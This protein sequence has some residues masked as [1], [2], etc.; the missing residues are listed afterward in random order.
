MISFFRFYVNIFYAFPF[1]PLRA[2]ANRPP[3]SF[4]LKWSPG[5]YFVCIT[6]QEVPHYEIVST[7]Y[8]S[9]NSSS[10]N[11]S[12]SLS[13]SGRSH[14]RGLKSA[15]LKGSQDPTTMVN[16]STHKPTL[17]MFV[18]VDKLKSNSLSKVFIKFV[19]S[20]VLRPI[21]KCYLTLDHWVSGDNS[22]R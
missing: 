20:A 7:P 17:V 21:F 14:S 13:T 22:R 3:I 12:V 1:T 5:K 8:N 2:H 10:G 4:T 18:K 6:N 19:L 16:L 9:S 11:F 15:G